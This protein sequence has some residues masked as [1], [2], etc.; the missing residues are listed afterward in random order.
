M[1]AQAV[2]QNPTRSGLSALAVALGAGMVIAG[3]MVSG[4]LV[5]AVR[6][7]ED[8]R[9]VAEGLVGQMDPIMKGI[10]AAILLAA[11]FIIFNT[12]GMSI[13]QRRRQLGLLRALG[14]TRGQVQ[15]LVL[16]EAL[17]IGGA[18]VALGLVAGPLAG[19]GLIALVK[20]ANIAI[21]GAFVEQPPSAVSFALAGG[22]GLGFTLLAAWVPARQATRLTPLM[23]LR[24]SATAAAPHRAAR[25]AVVGGAL[26][27]GLAAWLTFAPPAAW[28]Q[29]PL[30]RALTLA[31]G[32]A[33]LT[34]L[35]LL[36][37]GAISALGRALAAPL[38]RLFG[39]S[40]RLMADN[41][42][43]ERGRVLLTATTLAVGLTLIVTTAGFF[44]FYFNE[45]FGPAFKAAREA[46]GWTLATF[47]IEG[48]PAGYANLDSLRIPAAQLA[49]AQAVAGDRA[50]VAA[51]DFAIVPELSYFGENYF[52]FVL[53]PQQIRASG[54]YF[55]FSAGDWA[56]ALQ[57]MQA[58]CGLLL[59]PAVARQNGVG[60]GDALT[61][62]GRTGPVACTVAGI[63]QTFVGASL[64][65]AAAREQF[66]TGDPFLLFILQRPGT[67]RAALEAD[68]GAFAQR[69]GL[70]LL[71]LEKQLEVQT[72]VF[73]QLP[74][75]FN[76]LLLLAVAAAALGVVNTTL[77]SVTERRR[78]LAQLRALGATRGQVLA[79]VVGEAALVGLA[80]GALG[81]AAGAGLI[82][83]LAT[84]YGGNAMG[85]ADYDPWAAAVRTLA[86]ALR[87]GAW[88]LAVAPLISALAAYG[89]AARAVR[90]TPIEALHSD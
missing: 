19:R 70:Y 53:D 23:A 28:V 66:V 65:G 36:L 54:F 75:M 58:G 51:N 14:M 13:T 11:G 88:G 90:R 46:G 50:T 69:E 4:A 81:L 61:V 86:V 39:A 48:G 56:S 17:L 26:A 63:G 32:A 85:V 52:T 1:A 80:G 38:T 24:T 68:L 87:T 7:A 10:G 64:I 42:R 3:D 12:L 82:V 18:G 25:L 9:V 60:L 6:Q 41:L 89:P 15:R 49:A 47:S 21:L 73:D 59:T 34:A 79:L 43:R 40:G 16:A 22:L 29:P 74:A 31:L 84:A 44:Q 71:A 35:G 62:T 20:Q 30:D 5:G 57:V 83:I 27:L 55:T 33:W 72:Q 78:E 45:L 77:L 8:V 37:P 2:R 76:S 67:D